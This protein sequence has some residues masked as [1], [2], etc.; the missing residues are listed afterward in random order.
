MAR[1]GRV[2]RQ[3]AATPRRSQERAGT[4]AEHSCRQWHTGEVFLIQ[5]ERAFVGGKP[6]DTL[7]LLGIDA[8]SGQYFVRSF[9][10][11]GF[12]RNYDLAVVG[13]IW[14]LAGASERARIEFS[15]DGRTQTIAW[16]W[17]PRDC[18]LP[19]CDRVARRED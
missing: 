10:N 14:S 8:R 5:D 7:T 19:L 3:Y 16:E 6:F 4:V 17:K 12:Y 1:R 13:R 11:H 2:A 18:W 9:E 15:A